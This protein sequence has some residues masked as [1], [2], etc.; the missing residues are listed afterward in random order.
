MGFIPVTSDSSVLYQLSYHANWEL[1]TLWVRNIPYRRRM[2]QMNIEKIISLCLN[3]GETYE[4]MTDYHS[5]ARN[6]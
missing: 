3:C 5:Y 4:N 6:F 2:M 1:V